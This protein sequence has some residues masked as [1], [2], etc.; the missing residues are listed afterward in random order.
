MGKRQLEI[1][2]TERKQIKEIDDAAEAYVEARDKRMKL[3]EKEVATKQALIDVMKKHGVQTYRD[4]NADPPLHVI[5]TPGKDGVKVI[6]SDEGAE[7]EPS[8]EAP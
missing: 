5:V 6:A 4:M 8:G 1:A 3:T 7:S 2:G